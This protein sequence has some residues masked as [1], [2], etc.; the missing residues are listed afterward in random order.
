MG[1]IVY[2]IHAGSLKLILVTPLRPTLGMI[3]KQNKNSMFSIKEK[4][5]YFICTINKYIKFAF[6][7]FT[8]HI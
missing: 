5:M 3:P 8:K 1:Y 6:G 4:Q 2:G 7:E